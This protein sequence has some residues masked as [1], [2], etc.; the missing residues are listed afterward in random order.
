[1]ENGRGPSLATAVR[2]I[3][4]D[5]RRCRD[6]A[7]GVHW[8]ELRVVRLMHG[9]KVTGLPHARGLEY[10]VRVNTTCV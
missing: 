3:K 9:L 8:K 6:D 1:M 4:G 10:N 7:G 2:L 5:S